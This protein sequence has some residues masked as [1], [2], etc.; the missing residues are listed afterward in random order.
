MLSNPFNWSG[1]TVLIAEDDALSRK[2]MGL[3]LTP[4]GV[5]ILWA[6]TGAEALEL[7]QEHTQTDLAVLDIQMPLVNGFDVA[8]FLKRHHSHIPIIIQTA[9]AL[10][11]YRKLCHEI[12]C[13]DYITKPFEKNKLLESIQK[14]LTEV[15]VY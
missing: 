11:E 15:A 5:K 7:I 1:K 14:Q 10:P 3:Y 13:D 12:G 8:R 6:T 2:L 4:T 9:Y